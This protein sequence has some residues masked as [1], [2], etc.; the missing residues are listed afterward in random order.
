M[1]VGLIS[2]EAYKRVKTK[3]SVHSTDYTAELIKIL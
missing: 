3:K 2:T 1:R